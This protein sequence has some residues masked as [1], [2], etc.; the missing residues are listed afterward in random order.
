MTR[1]PRG[2]SSINICIALLGYLL[3]VGIFEG[4][5][6]WNRPKTQ[7]NSLVVSWHSKD[8]S[9]SQEKEVLKIPR[10]VDINSISVKTCQHSGLICN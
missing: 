7:L 1:F 5:G 2:V 9:E 10:S 6:S 8:S 3:N 4:D